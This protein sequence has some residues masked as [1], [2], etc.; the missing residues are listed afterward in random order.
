M[1]PLHPNNLKAKQIENSTTLLRSVKKVRSQ[2]KL[3]FA[4]LER[5]TGKYRESHIIL[6]HLQVESPQK[7]MPIN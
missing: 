4:K 6:Y 3:L 2:G 1:L 5:P 7:S